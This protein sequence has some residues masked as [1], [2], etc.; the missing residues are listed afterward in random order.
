MSTTPS[1]PL[2]GLPGWNA[3]NPTLEEEPQEPF[4]PVETEKIELEPGVFVISVTKVYQIKTV[5]AIMDVSAQ[6]VNKYIR[7]GELAAFTTRAGK[8]ISHSELT[9]FLSDIYNPAP[10]AYNLAPAMEARGL[11]PKEGQS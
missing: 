1:L 8:R 9:R 5:A 10:R 11:N 2:P 7:N 4:N 6:A 3:P